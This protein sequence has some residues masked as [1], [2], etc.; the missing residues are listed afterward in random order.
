MYNRVNTYFTTL[1]EVGGM[2]NCRASC[3]KDLILYCGTYYV[4]VGAD[5]AIVTNTQGMI[6][7]ASKYS[8]F[9]NYA[10]STNSNC[11]AFSDYLCTMH[12][13]TARTDGYIA[14]NSGIWGNKSG[15]IDLR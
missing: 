11:P 14:A 5:E 6:H 8:V 15:G 3:Y 1:A 4:S 7:R 12:D 2:K 10:L 9:Q 13:S